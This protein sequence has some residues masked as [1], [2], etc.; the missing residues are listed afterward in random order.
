MPWI[1]PR[2]QPSS[3]APERRHHN[4]QRTETGGGVSAAAAEH[5]ATTGERAERRR[6]A[7]RAIPGVVSREG[8]RQVVR[9][10]VS[11][12]GAVAAQKGGVVVA[13]AAAA[14]VASV[15]KRAGRRQGSGRE[16]SKAV[17]VMGLSKLAKGWIRM[18]L[19]R[20]RG[21]RNPPSKD[22]PY[23]STALASAICTAGTAF[24]NTHGARGAS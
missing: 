16:R 5:V 18:T 15:Y 9:L 3:L 12:E 17:A 4:R 14:H 19:W 23:P 6:G 7:G 10:E 13:D 20:W 24:P 1:F 8:G 2:S 11:G 21:G 22:T